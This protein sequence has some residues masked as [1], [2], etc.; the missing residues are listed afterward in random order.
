[1]IGKTISHYK[2]LE[3]LGGGGMGVVYKAE[4]TKLKRTVALKFLPQDLSR[5]DES[6]ERFIHEAQAASALDHN[7]ICTIYEIDETKPAPGEPGDGQMFIAM[8]CYDGETL[9]KKIEG[10]PLK[11]EDAIDISLQISEG[12]SKAHEKDIVHRD[13]K[14]ANVMLTQDGVVKIL[15]FGLAKLRGQTKLTK[16]GTTLGT[17]PYMSPEQ[18]RGEEVDNRTDV[19]SLGVLLYEM[20]T[21]QL[22]FKGDYHEAII[23]SIL[24]EDQEPITGLRTGV[25]MELERI[26]N[27]CLE[28]EPSARYQQTNELAV[29]LQK[30]KKELATKDSIVKSADSIVVPK[31]RVNQLSIGFGV[32]FILLLSFLGYFM[33]TGEGETT[34]RIPI[35]VVDFINQTN[36]PELDGLSG[37]LITAL[38]QSR[39]LNVFSRARMY[40]EFKQM[41][42]PDLQFVDEATGRAISKRANISALAVATI[43]KFGQLYTID[44]KVIDPQTG[45]RLFSTKVEGNGQESIPGLLDQLSEKTRIDLREPDTQVQLASRSVAE[46]TTPN[47]E[48]YQHYFKG[49][50]LINKV[51][52]SAAREE[53]EKAI[54]LDSTF[55]LAYYGLAHTLHW[56]IIV[57][58]EAAILKAI[59]YID[60]VPEKERY[61]IKALYEDVE[62]NTE[63]AITLYKELLELYP[64]EKEA[65]Y[66]IGDFSHHNADYSTATIFLEK[67]LA[68]DPSDERAIT[69][70]LWNARALENWDKMI[71]Y[72]KLYVENVP[73][74][75]ANHYLAVAYTARGDFD[76]ALEIY[77]ESQLTFPNDPAPILGLVDIHIARNEYQRAEVELRNGLQTP[78]LKH[79]RE[80]Y[81]YLRL[82]YMYEGKYNSAIK[83]MD[84]IIRIDKQLNEDDNLVRSYGEKAHMLIAGSKDIKG[85]T[86]ALEHGLKLR[87]AAVD[88]YFHERLFNIYLNLGEYEKAAAMEN[89]LTGIPYVNVIV[90]AYQQKEQ[91]NFDKAIR[92]FQFM[93]RKGLPVLKIQ[94]GYELSRSYYEVGRYA[95]AIEAVRRLQGIHSNFEEWDMDAGSPYYNLTRAI[96]FPKSFNLLGKI[97]EMKGDPKKAI[98]NTKKFLDLWKDADPG[99]QDLIDAKERLARLKGM[100]DK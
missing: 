41:N 9:K 11:L 56:H 76:K 99:L 85:A 68:L 40:D 60:K 3:K 59:Q 63:Q 81:R 89:E 54:A 14:P 93:T 87:S 57:G 46:V 19:F 10:G 72:A 16:V 51:K 17:A 64:S 67:V 24:N 49:E 98:Q 50:E 22:P 13:L 15:D 20:L 95:Q 6:K 1:M 94:C 5:D 70:L 52:I 44:F 31:K 36:E 4:D 90:R 66:N 97:Y 82:L 18:A 61:L 43:R 71:E 75:N 37:M 7:N 25:P 78:E 74:I 80:L 91:G 96:Y 27:K 32:V 42:R 33:F 79:K 92:D 38:E 23:Y 65:L 21:G 62:G 86:E 55:S 77:R 47:L 28:K 30:V 34:E 58:A 29:D 69:H 88:Y 45:D 8:A 39:R 100:T 12:L 83:I 35:A 73:S 84:E 48:A 53:F 26:V 2:I